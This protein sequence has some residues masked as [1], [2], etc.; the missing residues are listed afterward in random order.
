MNYNIGRHLTIKILK[1]SNY[2]IIYTNGKLRAHM[3]APQ[4]RVAHLSFKRYSWSVMDVAAVKKRQLEQQGYNQ[5]FCRP[6]YSLVNE[7]IDL[8]QKWRLICVYG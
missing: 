8:F 5:K 3:T 2:Y 1:Q 4:V 7:S 6:R